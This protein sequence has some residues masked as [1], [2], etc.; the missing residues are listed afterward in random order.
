MKGPIVVADLPNHS[1]SQTTIWKVTL[2]TTNPNNL[3][4]YYCQHFIS[5]LLLWLV[6]GAC[7]TIII[8]CVVLDS[9]G[10]WQADDWL[11]IARWVASDIIQSLIR[12]H[13][14]AL[15][16]KEAS[17]KTIWLWWVLKSSN[18]PFVAAGHSY[19]STSGIDKA[20]EKLSKMVGHPTFG[21]L[22]YIPG[23]VID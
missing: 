4:Q 5:L 7:Q 17:V 14:V 12:V 10:T 15:E 6:S 13:F 2:L 16:H 21:P 1:R 8:V 19:R 18:E 20:G 22:K 23:M 11:Q 3:N 9:G